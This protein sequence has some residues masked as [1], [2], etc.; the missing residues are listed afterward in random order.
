MEIQ[1]RCGEVYDLPYTEIV[2]S[3]LI[4]PRRLEEK[5]KEK[6]AAYYQRKKTIKK[7]LAQG[8]RD[9]KVDNKTKEELAQ[10]GY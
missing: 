10:F 3:L 7:Q 2:I 6:A 4:I 1:G 5:R 9:A 8:A